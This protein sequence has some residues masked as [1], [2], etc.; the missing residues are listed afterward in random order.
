MEFL[1]WLSRS[2]G[3]GDLTL[4]SVS[5]L[6]AACLISLI[7]LVLARLATGVR[8]ETVAGRDTATMHHSL[9]QVQIE[10]QTMS[11]TFAFQVVLCRKDLQQQLFQR[12]LSLSALQNVA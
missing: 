3:T 1:Q 9:D 2:Y 8:F 12:R 5:V 11:Q 10:L 6:G 4:D 7:L